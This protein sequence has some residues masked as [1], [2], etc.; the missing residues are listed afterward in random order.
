MP[1][2]QIVGTSLSYHR[3]LALQGAQSVEILKAEIVRFSP[4]I[5]KGVV[6][7]QRVREGVFALEARYAVAGQTTE[8]GVYKP[9]PDQTYSYRISPGARPDEYL[10]TPEHPRAARLLTSHAQNFETPHQ[11]VYGATV[12]VHYGWQREQERGTIDVQTLIDRALRVW[13][14]VDREVSTLLG[15]QPLSV[16]NWFE[17][18]PASYPWGLLRTDGDLVANEALDLR[19]AKIFVGNS[20]VVRLVTLDGSTLERAADFDIQKGNGAQLLAVRRGSEMLLGEGPTLDLVISFFD[21]GGDGTTAL[22]QQEMQY[23]FRRLLQQAADVIVN[24][25][26]YA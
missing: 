24:G 12:S 4:S 23:H 14:P 15:E 18:P 13:W 16:A 20:C 21:L 11:V 25:N 19:G 1:P 17:A 8:Y 7:A 26:P 10:I 2:L 3:G 22:Y 5:T 9:G 6:T